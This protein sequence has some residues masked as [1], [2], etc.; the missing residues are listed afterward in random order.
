MER[1]PSPSPRNRFFYHSSLCLR[2]S[3]L[4]CLCFFLLC[5][6]A[7]AQVKPRI[8][9]DRLLHIFPNLPW[10]FEIRYVVHDPP[11]TDMLRLYYDGRGDLVRWRTDDRGS[12][13]EVCHANLDDKQLHHLLETFRD[14]NF[15]DLPSDSEPLRTIAEHA[16]A[17][18]SVRVGRTTVRK[19]DRH[20][21]DNP[22]LVV[23]ETE[24]DSIETIIAADPK[25]KCGMESVPA[26][27]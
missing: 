9:F 6:A 8:D 1:A 2:V 13:A 21:H 14:K 25:T 5:T 19:I 24:L 18:V 17:T 26:R 10:D 20:E 7:G 11:N 16:D 22:G 23:V 3:V 12:L 15:N 4:K 27:P